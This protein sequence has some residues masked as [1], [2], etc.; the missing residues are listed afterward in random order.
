MKT[1]YFLLIFSTGVFINSCNLINPDEE[2][3]SYVV[4][5][6]LV[7]E[8]VISDSENISEVWIYDRGTSLGAFDLPAQVPIL[9]EGPLELTFRAGIKNNGV[10]SSRI[11]YPFYTTYSEVVNLVPFE[12]DT[13]VPFFTIK[14]NILIP[15]EAVAQFDDSGTNYIE[16][17]NSLADITLTTIEGEVFEGNGSGRVDL[18]SEDFFWQATSFGSMDLPNS[19]FVFLELD[20]KSENTFAVGLRANLSDGSQQNVL[21]VVVAPTDQETGVAEWNKIYI[22]LGAPISSYPNAVSY[23][24]LFESSLDSDN[25]QAQIFLDNIKVIHFE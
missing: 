24:V 10:S 12:N 8:G 13:V 9:K 5:P 20:Y 2:S 15:Q 18:N 16:T 25:T 1:L 23:N 7:F 4:I 17:V 11:L 22:D 3:P 19:E 14:D 21:S 6:E